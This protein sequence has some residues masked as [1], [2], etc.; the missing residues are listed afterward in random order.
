MGA[1]LEVNHPAFSIWRHA[2]MN[3]SLLTL[4]ILALAIA[5]CD[6]FPDGPGL[7][8]EP[9][10]TDQLIPLHTGNS[11]HYRELISGST[12]QPDDP[13]VI[14][15]VP[16]FTRIYN[17]SDVALDI[18]CDGYKMDTFND[19]THAWTVT[20]GGLL[21]GR[22]SSDKAIMSRSL[23][24]NPV[25]GRSY[26]FDLSLTCT[27][28]EQVTTPA[29]TFNCYHFTFNGPTEQ[30]WW[31]KGVGLVQKKVFGDEGRIIE[32]WVLDNYVLK[33]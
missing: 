15:K 20:F 33:N 22:M 12:T 16:S 10:T 8:L 31:A 9:Q 4:L 26:S 27:G 11:W 3:R 7:V 30:Y 5:G 1:T 28:I 13:W 19:G 14:T 23:P 29:G 32:Q 17:V 25:V 24:L 18:P 2:M 21:L 6:S